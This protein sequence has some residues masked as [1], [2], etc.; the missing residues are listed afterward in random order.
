MNL[1]QSGNAGQSPEA[2]SARG[3][4]RWRGQAKSQPRRNRQAR[5]PLR[6]QAGVAAGRAS[7]QRR[8][9]LCFPHLLIISSE[10]RLTPA[11][12][13]Q[14]CAPDHAAAR[15]NSCQNPKARPLVAS[16]A[17]VRPVC[18]HCFAAWSAGRRLLGHSRIFLF[19]QANLDEKGRHKDARIFRADPAVP[20]FIWHRPVAVERIIPT[21]RRRTTHPRHVRS[22]YRTMGQPVGQDIER[23][24]ELEPESLHFRPVAPK[25]CARCC[26]IGDSGPAPRRP[27]GH[28]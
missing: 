27:I 21:G 26:G 13:W 19:S 28:D 2:G 3:R 5:P 15:A 9:E 11:P 12:A 8:Y 4:G 16:G 18:A 14:D 23:E 7:G 22:F 20:P 1:G 6:Q 17:K 24:F 10:Y 25:A